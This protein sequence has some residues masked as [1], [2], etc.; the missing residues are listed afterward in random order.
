MFEFDVGH[1]SYAGLRQMFS[2][3]RKNYGDVSWRQKGKRLE[4]FIPESMS[5]HV[6][7]E[8]MRTIVSILTEIDVEETSEEEMSTSHEGNTVT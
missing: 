6:V 8:I 4:V 7:D 3:I 5:P 2:T 1:M